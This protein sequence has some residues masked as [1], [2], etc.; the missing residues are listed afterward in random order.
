MRGR[1]IK[2]FLFKCSLFTCFAWKSRLKY[3]Q[4][5]GLKHRIDRC[6]AKAMLAS[7]ITGTWINASLFFGSPQCTLCWD[8]PGGSPVLPATPTLIPAHT[9]K[10]NWPLLL[11]HCC[12]TELPSDRPGISF[13]LPDEHPAMAAL[14]RLMV[15]GHMSAGSCCAPCPRSPCTAGKRSRCLHPCNEVPRQS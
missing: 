9:C 10:A 13:L 2:P 15:P 3:K 5:Q 8:C 11:E 7:Q 12:G 14:H 4:R 6:S 1:K